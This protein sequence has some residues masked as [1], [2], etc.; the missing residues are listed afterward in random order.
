MTDP[1]ANPFAMRRE[2]VAERQIREARERG[3]FDD[4]PGTGKPIPH[5]DNPH[6]DEWWI[7][8]K[9]KKENVSF[10]PPTLA[11]RRE[12]DLTKEHL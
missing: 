8:E 9:L 4:L 3:A 6:D 7:R 2:N 12:I 11:I 10:L 5:L 1:I